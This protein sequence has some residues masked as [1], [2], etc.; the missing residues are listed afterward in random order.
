MSAREDD[1][2]RPPLGERLLLAAAPPA[3]ALLI[4]ALRA[5]LRLRVHGRETIEEYARSGKRYVHVFWHAHIL[6]MVYS[7]VGPQLVFMISR[8]KDG[9]LISRTVERFGYVLA[10]GSTTEGGA[11]AFREMVRAVRGGSDIGFTPD[12]PRGPSRVVQ[13]GCIAAARL[14]KAPIVPVAFGADRAW[15][16]NS[17]DRFVVPKPGARAL[18]AYGEPFSVG[19]DDDLED[20]AR[21]LGEEM[22]ALERFAEDHAGDLSVGRRA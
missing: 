5:T 17:W 8:S 4:R 9:E 19:P 7:Y 10:R 3:A 22:A 20:A 21:R 14:L 18:L 2:P 12:G 1:G 6:M 13:P 16:L 15:K 11:A